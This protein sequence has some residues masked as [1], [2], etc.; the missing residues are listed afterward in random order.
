[1]VRIAQSLTRSHK[2]KIDNLAREQSHPATDKNWRG[3]PLATW[4]HRG[5]LRRLQRV[6]R[7][8]PMPLALCPGKIPTP[9]LSDPVTET[10]AC[11]E[12]KMQEPQGYNIVADEGETQ[13]WETLCF[14][15]VASHR[16]KRRLAWAFRAVPR[17]PLIDS[18]FHLQH[19]RTKKCEYSNLAG[20]F[21]RIYLGLLCGTLLQKYLIQNEYIK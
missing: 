12:G 2:Q 16:G 19:S 6:A 5:V 10:I 7:N 20:S 18:N 3:V 8:R 17:F 14:C 1:M 13:G 21:V 9:S 4:H 15:F 11:Y